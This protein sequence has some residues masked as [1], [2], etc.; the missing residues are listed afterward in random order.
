MLFKMEDHPTR[1]YTQGLDNWNL[2]HYVKCKTVFF[3]N[4]HIFEAAVFL[5]S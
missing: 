2:S 1:R 4:G 3:Y 5:E